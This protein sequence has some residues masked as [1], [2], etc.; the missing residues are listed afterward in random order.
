V[1]SD[2]RCNDAGASVGK[3]ARDMPRRRFFHAVPLAVAVAGA[4]LC[5]PAV[6]DSAAAA[7]LAKHRAFVGWQLGDGSFRTLRLSRER[8][9]AE[10]AVTQRAVEYRIG[11]V[12]RNHYVFPKRAGAAEDSGFTGKIFWTSNDNG[13]TTPLYGDL[14]KFRLSFALLM[15]EGTTALE[16]ALGAPVSIDGRQLESVR[17]TVP[18]ADPI[19]VDVDP[20]TGAYV[21]A[22][23][24]PGGDEETTLQIVSYVDVDVS[25]KKMIGA[26]RDETRSVYRYTKIEPNVAISDEDLH[27]PGPR[28]SWTFAN[29]RPFPIAVTAQRV[30]VD[31]KVN[32]VKG[33]FILDT[34][35]NSVFLN[36]SFADRANVAKLNASGTAVGLYGARPSDVRRADTIEIGGN[37]LSNVIVDTPDFDSSDYRGLDRQNYDGLLGYDVFAGA[38]VTVDFQAQTMTIA[39]PAAQQ[40]DPAGLGV[41]TDTSGWIPTIPMTVNRTIAVNAM[42]DTGDPSAIVFGPDLLYKYHLRMARNIGV[43]VGIGSVECGNIDTLQIGPITYYGEL[44]CKIDTNLITGRRI[45]VGLDFLRHFTVVFDYPRGRLFLRPQR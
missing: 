5:A 12:Y 1:A 10:G 4:V 39:D 2:K 40:G 28:A 37:V 13:F 9:D 24:D 22:V 33:R 32:G 20:V 41:L 3:V 21:R 34:G 27:P 6:P 30:L 14:A 15:N 23:I 43:R 7:L 26:Y 36:R 31:A 16:G 8:V 29:S 25:G 38:V 17:L 11:I 44:A 45:L 18:H 19:E 35:A 42:L